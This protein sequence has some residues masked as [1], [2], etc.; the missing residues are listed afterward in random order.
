MLKIKIKHLELFFMQKRKQ[1]VFLHPYS[2]KSRN[3]HRK[4]GASPNNL[5]GTSIR[6]RLNLAL[7][8]CKAI[9]N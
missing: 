8:T 2:R 5:K 7:F 6:G 1:H 4:C 9:T 3:K